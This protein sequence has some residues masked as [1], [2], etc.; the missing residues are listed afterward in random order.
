MIKLN[1]NLQRYTVIAVFVVI[2]SSIFYQWVQEY[3]SISAWR[4]SLR[5]QIENITRELHDGGAK[6]D[7]P[8]KLSVP[9]PPPMVSRPGAAKTTVPQTVDKAIQ[10]KK[11]HDTVRDDVAAR[12]ELIGILNI[13]L[14]ESTSWQ[15]I[16]KMIFTVLTT[17]FGIKLIN[18]VFKKF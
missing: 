4:D 9:P 11:D 8:D 18:H 10:D 3:K 17:F 15:T 1:K 14:S 6:D 13:T 16:M 12:M 7:L 5:L 2:M